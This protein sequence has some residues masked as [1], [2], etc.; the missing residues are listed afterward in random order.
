MALPVHRPQ[1]IDQ[2]KAAFQDSPRV[3]VRGAGSKPG[4][5]STAGA[6]SVIDCRGLSGVVDYRPEEYTLTAWAGTPISELAAVLGARDQYLP[7]DPP[8]AGSGA[9]LGGTVAAGLSGAGR[10][11]FG[12]LRDFILAIRYLDGQGRDLRG[13]APVVKNAAGFDL[14]KLAVGSLGRLMVLTEITL[15]VFPRP[16]AWSSAMFE[17][18]NLRQALA[19]LTG[20][21]N[22]G[23]DLDC[24]ELDP[25]GCVLVRLAGAAGSLVARIARLERVLEQPAKTVLDPDQE[26]ALWQGRASF[27]WAPAGSA[28]VKIPLR[29]GRVESLEAALARL[30]S[31][32]RRYSATAAQAW[33]ALEPAELAL[34]DRLLTEMGL[35]GL[36]I[37]GAFPGSILGHHASKQGGNVF[38]RRIK[39]ALDPDGRLPPFNNGR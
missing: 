35:A 37:R 1:D 31:V 23:F 15:K 6:S 28:L 12:G 19:A 4:T 14:P 27:G 10:Q 25:P 2:L 20:L 34:L 3:V 29:A 9:T 8:L 11:R 26:A 17:F 39:Q 33:L 7:F 16:L 32:E 24:L 22:R 5:W 36:V 30:G 38:W 21:A 18:A 13:G